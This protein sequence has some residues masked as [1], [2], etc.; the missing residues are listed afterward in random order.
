VLEI[1]ILMAQFPSK[2][3]AEYSYEYRTLGLGYAN[4][5]SLLMIAGVPYDSPEA[6]AI[7]GAVSSLLTSESYAASALLAKE[8]GTF[9]H[10]EKNKNDMLRVIRNHR[11]AAYNTDSKEYENLTIKPIGIDEKYCP[12]YLLEEAKKS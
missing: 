2:K 9:K 1:S 4:L 6:L 10:Y 12:N 7:T 11:R 5:G 3:I 8:L